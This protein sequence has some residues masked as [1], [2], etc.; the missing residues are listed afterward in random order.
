MA[1]RYENVV[2]LTGAIATKHWY[3]DATD[4]YLCSCTYFAVSGRCEHEQCIHGLLDTGG[5]D[6]ETLGARTRRGRKAQN[7]V[8]CPRGLSSAAVLGRHETAAEA[9]AQA[10]QRKRMATGRAPQPPAKGLRIH[11]GSAVTSLSDA[12]A[13]HAMDRRTSKAGGSAG[14]AAA[15][16]AQAGGA[17]EVAPSASSASVDPITRA[18]GPHIFG[19]DFGLIKRAI[20]PN[21]MP[22]DVQI[23]FSFAGQESRMCLSLFM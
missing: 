15:G 22:T 7:I 14:G 16:S 21:V 8:A 13:V 19:T 5:L 10:A 17:A 1:L 9:E 4:L 20:L 2:V 6:M 23:Y 12:A 11:P 18:K 3:A